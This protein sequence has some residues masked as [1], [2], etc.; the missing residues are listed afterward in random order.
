MEDPCEGLQAHCF[1]PLAFHYLAVT[2]MYFM[3]KSV[4]LYENSDCLSSRAFVRH[5]GSRE[6]GAGR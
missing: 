5:L 1:W 2:Y 3:G 4:V 6:H